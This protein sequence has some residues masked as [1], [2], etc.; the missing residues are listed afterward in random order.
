MQGLAAALILAMGGGGVATYRASQHVVS[1]ERETADLR[2]GQQALARGREAGQGDRA[3]RPR[4]ALRRRCAPGPGSEEAR[5]TVEAARG[6]VGE[7]TL[8]H[9]RLRAYADALDGLQ[10]LMEGQERIAALDRRLGDLAA[11]AG[12]REGKS[13][14]TAEAG[15]APRRWRRRRAATVRSEAYDGNSITC[16]RGR[17]PEGPSTGPGPGGAGRSRGPPVACA[18]GPADPGCDLN[19]HPIF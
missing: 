10:A 14:A 18:T 9:D 8:D 12:E 17:S 7:K 1:L 13:E 5:Q 16:A 19:G 11:W 4:P 6:A 2:E 3:R 15:R